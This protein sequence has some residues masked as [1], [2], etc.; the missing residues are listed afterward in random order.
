MR[1]GIAIAGKACFRFRGI[2]IA[3]KAC[4]RFRPRALGNDKQV[5]VADAG[6]NAADR[7]LV[8]KHAF[9]VT[10]AG[11]FCQTAHAVHAYCVLV[12]AREGVVGHHAVS[13]VVKVLK[14][15]G[16]LLVGIIVHFVVRVRWLVV[17]V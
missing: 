11:G 7:T 12:V 14:A 13:S 10:L 2:A 17:R 1:R 9:C 3:G 6:R 16:A 5:E 8:R 4:F 15:H